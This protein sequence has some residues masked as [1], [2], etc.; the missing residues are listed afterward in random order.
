MIVAKFAN[1][2]AQVSCDIWFACGGLT[3]AL[4]L[5]LARTPE[6]VLSQILDFRVAEVAVRWTE[7]P[8]SKLSLLS[9]TINMLVDIVRIRLF[10]FM[11]IWQI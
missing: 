9:A 8:G 1:F 6:Q 10:Y 4:A 5:A 3:L 7:I 11:G 2:A